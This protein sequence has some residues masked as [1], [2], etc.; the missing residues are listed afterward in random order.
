MMDL[1]SFVFSS[2]VRTADT[3]GEFSARE[4]GDGSASPTLACEFGA[5]EATGVVG[6]PTN[7]RC[8][9]DMYM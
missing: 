5:P 3:A 6:V 1:T 4:R 2:R 9:C 7:E 8:D